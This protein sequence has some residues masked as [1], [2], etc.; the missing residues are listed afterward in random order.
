[1]TTAY[2]PKTSTR[3][4]SFAFAATITL[5]IMGSLDALATS[6][7]SSAALLAQQGPLQVACM[8]PSRKG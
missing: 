5:A 6:D 4:L 7:Q 1:M 3:F 8:D 2:T